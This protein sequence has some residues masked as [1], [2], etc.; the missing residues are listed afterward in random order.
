MAPM[1]LE[2][3]ENKSASTFGRISGRR[4]CAATAFHV[5]TAG[6]KGELRQA[7]NA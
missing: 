3:M 6:P 1:G 7:S 4:V 5:Q 2:L